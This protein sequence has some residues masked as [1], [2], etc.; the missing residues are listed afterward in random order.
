[1]LMDLSKFQRI[2]SRLDFILFYC[3][4]NKTLKKNNALQVKK[5]LFDAVV[6]I[7]VIYLIEGK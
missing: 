6:Q 3:F 5:Y 1:M 2:I 7:T 4:V